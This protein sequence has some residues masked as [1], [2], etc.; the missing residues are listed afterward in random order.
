[1]KR[2][3]YILTVLKSVLIIEKILKQI[4]FRFIFR[5]KTSYNFKYKYNKENIILIIHSAGLQYRFTV[6]NV[7]QDD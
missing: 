6:G 4:I 2:E 1:M 3:R 7:L 5:F